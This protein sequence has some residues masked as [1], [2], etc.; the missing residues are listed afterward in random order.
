MQI[1]LLD[2]NRGSSPVVQEASPRV[3]RLI[4]AAGR[5]L[6]SRVLKLEDQEARCIPPVRHQTGRNGGVK[7]VS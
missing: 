1:V 4:Q 5:R 6:R 7:K 3:D 2:L